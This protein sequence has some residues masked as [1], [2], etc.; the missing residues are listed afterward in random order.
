MSDN[1]FIDSNV[2]I[3]ALMTGDDERIA[4]ATQ[5]IETQPSIVV[6]TQIVNEVCNVLLRKHRVSN[7]NIITYIDYFYQEYVVTVLDESVLRLA[8]Q[9][10][11]R[12]NFSFWDSLVVSSAIENDCAIIYSEDMQHGLTIKNTLIKNPFVSVR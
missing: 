10:R 2:W 3:Y 4:A 7:D 6:S 1:V 11:M 5:L 12:Y 8:A 9:L